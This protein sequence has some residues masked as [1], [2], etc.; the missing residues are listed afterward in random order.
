MKKWLPTFLTVLFLF[1]LLPLSQAQSNSLVPFP[2]Q[3]SEGKRWGY[4]D[5]STQKWAILP[6][7][8]RADPFTSLEEKPIAWIQLSN[9]GYTLIDSTGKKLIP[10]MPFDDVGMA[11]EGTARFKVGSHWGYLSTSDGS[12]LISP[13]YLQAREFRE[14]VAAVEVTSGKW[15]FI[16]K[17][18]KKN[19][20]RDF[21][22]AYSFLDGRAIAME[23][24]GF[25]GVINHRGDWILPPKFGAIFPFSAQEK[26]Y[27]VGKVDR[28]KYHFIPFY[29]IV[30]STGLAISSF[31]VEEAKIF[32]ESGAPVKQDGHW[33]YVDAMSNWV[34]T[35][36]FEDVQA[37]RSFVAPAKKDGLW[38]IIYHDPSRKKEFE[39]ITPPTWEAEPNMDI[40][41]K[42]ITPTPDFG[43]T[44]S[45]ALVAIP[46]F[47][48][49]IIQVDQYFYDIKGNKL[50]CYSNFL[51]DG[52]NALKK[53]NK[54]LA[55]EYFEKALAKIPNDKAALYGIERAK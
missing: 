1:T 43:D 18:G 55:K 38:G 48:N 30:N 10:T 41:A 4:L 22:F 13:T 44:R 32:Q 40:F 42:D 8:L 15:R 23:E 37:F 17:N 36:Q 6:N 52:E 49:K 28:N 29:E 35:P 5:L 9:Q 19:M 47:S 2:V 51:L 7:Y 31:K 45:L 3:L 26:N 11:S 54:D 46:D 34:I 21:S 50:Q 53:G 12:F 25:Y 14:G 20:L 24:G 33:G 39:W 16:N 27:V